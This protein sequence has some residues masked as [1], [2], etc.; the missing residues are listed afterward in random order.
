MS[1]SALESINLKTQLNN[2]IKQS[3]DNLKNFKNDIDEESQGSSTLVLL[4]QQLVSEITEIISKLENYLVSENNSTDAEKNSYQKLLS[5]LN[6]VKKETAK[7]VANR[8]VVLLNTKTDSV[9]NDVSCQVLSTVY[10]RVTKLVCF[11][12]IDN[13][14]AFWFYL[15]LIVLIN[16]LVAFFAAKQSNLFRKNYGY[17]DMISDEM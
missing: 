4:L 14:N 6:E 16:I 3:I 17:D 9:M 8:V 15:V 11:D 12:Y 10:K 13:F 1:D 7:E 5:N 2:F